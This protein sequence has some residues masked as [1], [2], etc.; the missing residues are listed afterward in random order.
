[1]TLLTT[2]ESLRALYEPTCANA[3]PPRSC[4]SSTSI[5]SASSRC[6]PSWCWPPSG[7]RDA[8]DASPRGGEPGFVQVLDESHAADPD[9]PGNN[10]LD[11]L[12]NVLPH[13]RRWACLFLVPG[14]DETLRVNGT[15]VLS[16]DAPT[17]WTVAPTIDASPKLVVAV[18]VQASLPALRQGADALRSCGTPASANRA[19]AC[20]AMGEMLRDQVAGKV[21]R[22][23]PCLRRRSRCWSATGRRCDGGLRKT[24]LF[25]KATL[26]SGHAPISRSSPPPRRRLS[27]GCALS[28]SQPAG[29]WLCLAG[30][31]CRGQ[32]S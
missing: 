15:A 5:A 21:S 6:R 4:R 16:V 28:S 31:R 23:G 13:G 19:P 25:C 7:P 11:T 1:M 18:T 30:R 3:P 12:Q 29:V 22:R 26:N 20:P 8:L 9:S 10:R 32:R 27:R 14:V 24:R 17:G 2:P